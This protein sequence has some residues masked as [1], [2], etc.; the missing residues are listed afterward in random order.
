MWK[1]LVYVDLISEEGDRWKFIFPFYGTDDKLIE[2]TILNFRMRL[3]KEGW[4]VLECLE[5][6]QTW[7]S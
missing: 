2:L 4:I 1:R 3:H 6:E 5:L 7:E